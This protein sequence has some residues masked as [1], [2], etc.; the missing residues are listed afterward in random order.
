MFIDRFVMGIIV[1]ILVEI[2]AVV[3]IGLWFGDR[4]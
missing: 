2:I 3:V 1:T 4:K